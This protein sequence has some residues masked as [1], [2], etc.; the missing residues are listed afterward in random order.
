MINSLDVIEMAVSHAMA[1]GY[2]ERVNQYEPKSA[3]IEG[4]F[5]AVWVQSI[6]PYAAQSGLAATSAYLILNVRI[7]TNMIAEPQDMIDPRIME[8]TDELM[9]RYSADFTLDGL[10]AAVD[11]LG[12]GTESL[13][14]EAGYIQIGSGDKGAMFRV[15]TITLPLILNDAWEQQP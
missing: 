2:F 5:A 7:Y 14:A 3:P 15:M 13:R 6:A 11:L 1:T 8:A 10:V 12:Q 4:L 9:R